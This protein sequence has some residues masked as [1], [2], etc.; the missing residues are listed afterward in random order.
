M[1]DESYDSLTAFCHVKGLVKCVSQAAR[2]DVAFDTYGTWKETIVTDVA[3]GTQLR[4]CLLMQFL[5]LDFEVVDR[6]AS[7]R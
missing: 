2:A 4:I 6:L 7:S 3:C 1:V 5:D